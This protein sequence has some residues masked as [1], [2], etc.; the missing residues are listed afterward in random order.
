LKKTPKESQ[1]Q[2]LPTQALSTEERIL[3]AALAEFAQRGLAGARVDEIA[4]RAKINNRR[5]I[6][7]S[8]ARTSCFRRR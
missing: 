3:T 4:R 6:I 1:T 8:A 7:I 5:F 2:A